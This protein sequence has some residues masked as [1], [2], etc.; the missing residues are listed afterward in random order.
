M[1]GNWTPANCYKQQLPTHPRRHK[2]C[3][4]ESLVDS[5]PIFMRVKVCTEIWVGSEVSERFS[6]NKNVSVRRPILQLKKTTTSSNRQITS[7]PLQEH[8]NT[9]VTNTT[10]NWCHK[11]SEKARVLANVDLEHFIYGDESVRQ[12]KSGIIHYCQ[13]YESLSHQNLFLIR[14][15]FD[16]SCVVQSLS[17]IKSNK[18]Y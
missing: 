12:T 18:F 9:Q 8:V 10:C 17:S 13:L 1:F 16:V 6:L 3:F 2:Y 15:P 4:C 7:M 11:S 5:C 14:K